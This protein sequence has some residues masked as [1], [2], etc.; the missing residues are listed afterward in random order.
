VETFA[1]KVGLKDEAFKMHHVFPGKV[2]LET[3]YTHP[4]YSRASE[5]LAGGDYITTETGTGLVHTAPGH[6]QEDYLTVR[7]YPQSL[8]LYKLYRIVILILDFNFH[9]ETIRV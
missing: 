4:L 1:A 8:S 9:I 6:G 7:K 3:K 2:L 5:V